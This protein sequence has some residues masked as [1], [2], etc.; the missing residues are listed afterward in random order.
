MRV[1]HH[2]ELTV[3]LGCRL[4]QVEN[5][6]SRTKEIYHTQKESIAR[7]NLLKAEMNKKE[8]NRTKKKIRPGGGGACL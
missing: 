5:Y 7:N 3:L 2:E 6:C 4:R 1:T 8:S